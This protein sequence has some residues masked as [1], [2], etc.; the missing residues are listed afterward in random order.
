LE[1]LARAIKQ[2]KEIKGTQTEKA[3]VKLSLIA[4]DMILK[5]LK[6]SIKKNPLRSDK[7]WQDTINIQKSVTFLYTNHE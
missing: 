4:D 5:D 1:F 7:L 3:E 6:D 2:E